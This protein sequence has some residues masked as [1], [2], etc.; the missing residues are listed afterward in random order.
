VLHKDI[1]SDI[2]RHE[3]H[4]AM[5]EAWA[6]QPEWTSIHD[7]NQLGGRMV[8]RGWLVCCT[9]RKEESMS[10]VI[11]GLYKPMGTNSIRPIISVTL[12]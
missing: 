3:V 1:L 8:A 10:R 12:P 2:A 7:G 11:D 5:L 6:G 4:R 9:G